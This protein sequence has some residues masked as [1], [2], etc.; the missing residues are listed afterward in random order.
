VTSRTDA[1]VVQAT[2]DFID[3]RRGHLLLHAGGAA[4]AD[5]RTVVV[6]GASGAG[7]TTL[8][9]A[10]VGQGL[11]YVT[12]ET[13]S[14]DPSSLAIEP[15]P[16]PLTVKPGSHELLAHLRPPS[17]EVSEAG[18]WQ[19]PPERLGGLPLPDALRP[20]L[21]VFP[22]V[23]P[24]A[25]SV[26]AEPVSRARAAFVLGEQSSAMWA[27]T[28]RPL[29]A[30]ARLV[31]SVPAF[32]VTY[33]DA[34]GAAPVIVGLLEQAADAVVPPIPSR[35]EPAPTSSVGP[36]RAAGVDWIV[37]DGEAVLFDGRHLHHLDAP[38]AAV[39]L[40][41]DGRQPLPDLATEVAGHFGVEAG[42]VLLD[43]EDLVLVLRGRGLVD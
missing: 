9:A 34:F 35:P 27:I 5:G 3:A 7:K 36:R 8:T 43:V 18:N 40:C 42:D 4:A 29:A 19:L 16:K 1:D 26:T 32:Q 41:L 28:P 10:L 23:D 39:W 15:F 13:V 14:L 21:V 12:D 37:L 11:A 6:H 24:S 38:G 2:L 20:A 31:T 33:G 30:L 17:S 22:E 25:T